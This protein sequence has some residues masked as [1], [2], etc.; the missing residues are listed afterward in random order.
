MEIPDSKNVSSKYELKSRRKGVGRYQT[1]DLMA[2]I[3][4]LEAA[5]Q[6]REKQADESSRRVFEE[7]DSK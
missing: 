1:D 2:L 7:F 6:Y 4:E 5:E 3:G